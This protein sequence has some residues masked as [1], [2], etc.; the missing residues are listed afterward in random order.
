MQGCFLVI[1]FFIISLIDKLYI[2]C[3]IILIIVS[4]V[5]LQEY[6]DLLSYFRAGLEP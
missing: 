2:F 5:V 1:E 6:K 4:F 3:K